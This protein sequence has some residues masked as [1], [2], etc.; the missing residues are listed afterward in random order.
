L[1]T[2]SSTVNNTTSTIVTPRNNVSTTS[3]TKSSSKS[4]KD[5]SGGMSKEDAYNRCK[6]KIPEWQLNINSFFC[7]KNKRKRCDSDDDTIEIV[8]NKSN[9]SPYSSDYLSP[10]NRLGD[11]IK[12]MMMGEEATEVELWDPRGFCSSKMLI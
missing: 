8:E 1:N 10:T 9:H 5:A 6:D 4:S 11:P 7:E 3:S 12:N 2:D